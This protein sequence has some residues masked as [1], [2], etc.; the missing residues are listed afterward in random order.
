MVSG[1]KLGQ[2]G[3][4][5]RHLRHTQESQY[6]SQSSQNDARSLFSSNSFAKLPIAE[7]LKDA[8]LGRMGFEF[9][10]H[11]QSRGIAAALEGRDV[12]GSAK[13][14]SGKTLAFLIPAIQNLVEKNFDTASGTG[15]IIITPTRELALQIH[16]VAK[17]LLDGG[18]YSYGYVIGG[19]SMKSE[20]E[21]FAENVN[22]LV[23]TP[24]RLLDHLINTKSFNTKSLANLVIDEADLILQQGFEEQMTQILKI[25]PTARQTFLY[26]AT[27]TQKVEDLSR[28]SL[29]DPKV[30]FEE[31][32]VATVE[33]LDQGY[34]VCEPDQKFL[35]LFTF[36]RRNPGKKMMVFFS[37]CNA[38]KF[39]SDL[40]NYVQFP[41]MC[42]HGNQKQATRSKT[43]YEF[44][45]AE[46]AVL[47]C[48]DV[49]ARGLD[50]PAVDWII[51]YDPPD[52]PEE[53]IHRVGRTARVTNTGKALL[54]LLAT[55]LGFLRYLSAARVPLTEYEFPTNRLAQV[56]TQF[57]RLVEKNYHL[58][59]A[60]RDG[61]RSYL[62]AY[63]S[64]QHKDI[65][66]ANLLDLQKVGYAFGF[67]APPR[68]D[69]NLKS[70]GREARRKDEKQFFKKGGMPF[71]AR[72]TTGHRE[73]SDKRSFVM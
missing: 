71:S 19:T 6:K 49:A 64:H 35:L 59:K 34:V 52:Q 27:Q 31:A 4:R 37:S 23:A 63:V 39:Y 20:T 43:Y 61:Y 21:R 58:N 29:S 24:G 17:Q 42:I 18:Q 12:L 5:R 48:T 15:V 33:T 25:L 8:L 70:G 57:E 44:C 56:Q 30:I 3:R 46:G 9:M 2:N 55:E 13:T 67:K 45:S 7:F 53:Y 10:T 50:I 38:V 36:L 14:G 68:V 32:S 60:A 51:Q 41:V 65:F 22:V 26:S 28:V 66:N 72:N 54:F 40:M 69:L 16:D 62:K 73:S 47:L 11:I 1:L